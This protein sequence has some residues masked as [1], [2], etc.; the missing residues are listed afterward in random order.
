MS[1]VSVNAGRCALIILVAMAAAEDEAMLKLLSTCCETYSTDKA[2]QGDQELFGDIE[3]ASK[4]SNGSSSS[5]GKA[6]HEREVDD[7]AMH[8]ICGLYRCFIRFLGLGNH[9]CQ[10]GGGG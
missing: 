3:A 2:K 1:A 10:K 4:S 6:N 7:S 9:A 8:H 5:D